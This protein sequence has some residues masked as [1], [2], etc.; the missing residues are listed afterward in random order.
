ML[1]V[2]ANRKCVEHSETQ[3]RQWILEEPRANLSLVLPPFRYNQLPKPEVLCQSAY[4][5]EGTPLLE[6]GVMLPKHPAE[7]RM[8]KSELA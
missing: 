2:H 1:R 3:K 8:V 5:K 4:T 7:E 6:G